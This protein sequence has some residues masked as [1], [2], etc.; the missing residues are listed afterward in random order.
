[1]QFNLVWRMLPP[2]A[3]K[4]FIGV[5]DWTPSQCGEMVHAGCAWN[6]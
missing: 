4:E 6:D 3:W 2:Q 5:V 1:M